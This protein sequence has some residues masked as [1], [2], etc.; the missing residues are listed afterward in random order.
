MVRELLGKLILG[1]IVSQIFSK[2]KKKTW[3]YW[4]VNKVSKKDTKETYPQPVITCLKLKQ[5][6]SICSKLTLEKPEWCQWRWS[7]LFI[8]SF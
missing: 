2:K 5:V 1:S 3:T 4:I 7:G 8:V 6:G